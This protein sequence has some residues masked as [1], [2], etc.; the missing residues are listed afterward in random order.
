M[1]R[2]FTR[3]NDDWG[4]CTKRM[5]TCMFAGEAGECSLSKCKLGLD[6]DKD[7]DEEHTTDKDDKR[8]QRTHL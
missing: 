4:Y 1:S 8:T 7:P 3:E 6:T 5:D 2:A